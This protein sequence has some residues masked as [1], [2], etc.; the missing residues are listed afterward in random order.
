[1]AYQSFTITG[2]AGGFSYRCSPVTRSGTL[3]CLNG[4]LWFRL[5]QTATV[6]ASGNNNSLTNPSNEGMVSGWC[7]LDSGDRM[8][9]GTERVTETSSTDPIAQID[10]FCETADAVCLMH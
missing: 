5:V 9:F 3:G 6:S 4:T 1:M 8:D 2:G 7:R 10:I